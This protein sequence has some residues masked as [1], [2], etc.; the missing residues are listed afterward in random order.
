M[1][2]F[3]E[4]WLVAGGCGGAAGGA[5]VPMVAGGGSGGA[6][7]ACPGAAAKLENKPESMR[8]ATANRKVTFIELPPVNPLL[9][10]AG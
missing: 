8:T 9:T 5:G 10:C 3:G 1:I 2:S 7:C 4:N 6:V